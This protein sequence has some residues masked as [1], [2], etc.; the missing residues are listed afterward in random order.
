MYIYINSI[1][2][3][4]IILLF[5]SVRSKKVLPGDLRSNKLGSANREQK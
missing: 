4:C 3:D 1:K 2:M 5:Y